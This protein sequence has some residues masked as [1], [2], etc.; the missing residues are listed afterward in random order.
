MQKVTVHLCTKR[1]FPNNN[2]SQ[3]KMPSLLID[4]RIFFW[5]TF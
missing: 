4:E 5:N 3:Q 2:D 1:K